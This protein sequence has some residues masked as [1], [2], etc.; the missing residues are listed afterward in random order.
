MQNLNK[1]FI[2]IFS[3]SLLV[4]IL[5]SNGV[6]GMYRDT[7]GSI[8]RL[9]DPT[10]FYHK[11]IYY[12]YGTGGDKD[13][14]QGFVVYTSSD[15]KSWKGPVGVSEGYALKKGDAFG[16]KG[17]WAPQVFFHKNKFYMA[18]TANEQIAIA[19]SDSPLGPFKQDIKKPLID[20]KRNI[21]PFVFI[22]DNG[23]KYLYHVIV[24]N[25]GNRIFVAE[26]KKDLSKIRDKTLTKC[27][28]ADTLWENT[29]KAKWSVVEGPTVIK[30]NGL[31]YL[32][33]SANDFRSPDYAVG[34]AVSKSPV[35]P[36]KKYSGNP[37][38]S[39]HNTGVNGSG[40]GDLFKDKKDN[41]WYVFH[42]HYSESKVGPRKTALVK[43]GFDFDSNIKFEA[44]TFNY[45]YLNQVNVE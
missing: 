16:D 1:S 19:I 18:Y 34:Y 38:L 17:F 12:L 5:I 11:D 20:Q 29:E 10:I 30:K 36:W 14:N 7:D 31:Y 37:G 3:V 35:G 26:L 43:S 4:N 25:G 6:F 15:L 2:T 39:K 45:L 41:W 8:I 9:A 23:K 22:D 42:T 13:T 33:Y 28:E 27:V 21:D 44:S 24:A 40:H 32:I